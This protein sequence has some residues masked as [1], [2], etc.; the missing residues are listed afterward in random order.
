[1]IDDDKARDKVSQ[2]LRENAPTIRAEIE[3]EINVQRAEQHRQ[4]Q[5]PHIP[6]YPPPPQNGQPGPYYAPQGWGHFSFYG[7]AQQAPAPGVAVGPPT[8]AMAPPP[9]GA[10]PPPPPTY[11]AHPMYPGYPAQFSSNSSG[12]PHSSQAPSPTPLM[13]PQPPPQQ[14]LQPTPATVQHPPE[15]PVE[16]PRQHSIFNFSFGTTSQPP[17]SQQQEAEANDDDQ[18]IFGA[19]SAVFPSSLASWTK[20]AFS[21]GGGMSV[22]SNRDD[23]NDNVSVA[24]KPLQY[25]HR[26]EDDNKGREINIRSGTGCHQKAQ[27]TSKDYA[28]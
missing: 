3:T 28:Q 16:Q 9:T 22:A 26:P 11:Q 23:H 19:M 15:P 18:S 13:E 17:E 20:D 1:M 5:Q 10:M 7:Y 2:A 25:V 14:P 8:G 27:K 21:I 12:S 4:H 24:S 6:H